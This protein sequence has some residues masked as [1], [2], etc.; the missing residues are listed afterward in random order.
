VLDHAELPTSGFPK[1]GVVSLGVDP[2][3]IADQRTF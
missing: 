3:V 1:V 2:A